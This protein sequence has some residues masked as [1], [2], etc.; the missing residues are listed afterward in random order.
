MSRNPFLDDTLVVTDV[1][2]APEPSSVALMLLGVGI[3]FVARKRMGHSR[4]AAF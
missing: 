4:L 1:T 3:L 2:T